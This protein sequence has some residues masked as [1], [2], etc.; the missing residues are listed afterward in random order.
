MTAPE[1]IWR[2]VRGID[3]ATRARVADYIAACDGEIRSVS[4]EAMA[5]E[6][7]SWSAICA[8]GTLLGYDGA[9]HTPEIVALAMTLS[10]PARAL[11]WIQAH[12][13]WRDE[14]GER[15]AH[16][17]RTLERLA[18]DCDDSSILLVS[19]A[20][21]QGYPAALCAL[22]VG[23]VVVHGI[24]AICLSSGWVWGDPTVPGT[25]REWSTDPLAHDART[26]ERGVIRPLGA[27]Q[28]IP[29]WRDPRGEKFHLGSP[30]YK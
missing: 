21:A 30:A 20:L 26:G 16:P 1:G 10:T 3:D 29:R 12:V 22:T 2:H 25:L 5:T 14:P 18:G 7:P 15:L 23:S 13:E 4:G 11:A 9:T 19:L 27:E 8:F 6:F 24:A 17:R 28:Q